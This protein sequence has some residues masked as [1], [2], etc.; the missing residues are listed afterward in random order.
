MYGYFF[1]KIKFIMMVKKAEA[2]GLGSATN[3]NESGSRTLALLW[4][5]IVISLFGFIMKLF[6]FYYT[7][8]LWQPLSGRIRIS[9]RVFF[10][11]QRPFFTNGSLREQV[12]Y[13]LEVLPGSVDPAEQERILAK[14]RM[15]G[16]TGRGSLQKKILVTFFNKNSP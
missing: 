5:F 12:T 9:H 11:P 4:P 7:R 15:A 6:I 3:Y 13:P 8:G 16:M 10:L 2:S 14:F 1:G